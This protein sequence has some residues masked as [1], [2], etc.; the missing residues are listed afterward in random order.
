MK[1]ISIGKHQKAGRPVSAS[2]IAC[3]VATFSASIAAVMLS[4]SFGLSWPEYLMLTFT[5]ASLT[6]GIVFTISEM[7][8]MTANRR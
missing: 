7:R 8:R 2:G 6:F 4:I 3:L 1:S 5:A